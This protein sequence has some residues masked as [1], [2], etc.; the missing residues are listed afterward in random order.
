[1]TTATIIAP[2]HVQAGTKRQNLLAEVRRHT[3]QFG[4]RAERSSMFLQMT[5]A[6]LAMAELQQRLEGEAG[7]DAAFQ[8]LVLL[9]CAVHGRAPV[10]IDVFERCREL[11]E[12]SHNPA[13]RALFF[14]CARRVVLGK[15]VC[16]RSPGRK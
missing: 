3:E 12:R 1:M 15:P 7:E 5:P 6:S 10:G 13:L 14:T 11:A 2:G 16:R 9:A 4:R 8:C